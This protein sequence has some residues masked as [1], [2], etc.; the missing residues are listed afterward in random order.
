MPS[1]NCD[2]RPGG[3]AVDLVIVHGISLPPGEFGN[4]LIHDLFLNRLDWRR[5]EYF[6]RIIGLRV[7]SHLLIERD[8]ALLQF[9]PLERRAW[10]AGESCFQG[11]ARCND[12]S[13]GVELEGTDDSA[14]TPAQY[15]VLADVITRLRA[16]Y[17]GIRSDRIV[18]HCHVSPGRKTDPGASFRWDELGRLLGEPA[19]WGPAPAQ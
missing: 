4:G 14:Y 11:R 15:Q 7:S 1:P 18:G 10:H 3:C 13:I 8:G 9:V 5:H 12:F 2:D 17:P 6:R 19:D 16:I